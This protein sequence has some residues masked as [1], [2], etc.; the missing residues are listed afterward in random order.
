MKTYKIIYIAIDGSEQS[1]II[2][3]PTTE[4]AISKFESEYEHE[5]ILKCEKQ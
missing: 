4:K 5:V 1:T 2:N 3:A